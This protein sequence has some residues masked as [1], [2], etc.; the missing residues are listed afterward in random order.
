VNDGAGHVAEERHFFLVDDLFD[1]LPVHRAQAVARTAQKV[2]QDLRIDRQQLIQIGTAQLAQSSVIGRGRLGGPGLRID[3]A[4]LAEVLARAEG[5]EHLLPPGRGG[6]ADGDLAAQDDVEAVTG[7]A[8]A[9]D[10]LVLGKFT[11]LADGLGRLQLRG[12]KTVEELA[13]HGHPSLRTG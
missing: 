12:R 5:D 7:L 9:E 11:D 2:E 8:F 10:G 6:F 4:H 1:E 13:G 3:H